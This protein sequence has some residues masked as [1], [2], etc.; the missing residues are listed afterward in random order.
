M[1]RQRQTRPNGQRVEVLQRALAEQPH[2]VGLFWDFASLHQHP[3]GGE[4]TTTEQAAFDR[5][6]ER[7][8]DLYASAIGTTVLQLKEIPSRPKEYDGALCLFDLAAGVDEAAP[9]R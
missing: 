9:R 5:A 3:P 6:L 8:G 4:R 1:A 2:I 7:M